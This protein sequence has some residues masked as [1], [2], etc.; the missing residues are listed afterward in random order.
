MSRALNDLPSYSSVAVVTLAV[1]DS[2]VDVM[3]FGLTALVRL[4]WTE[5]I[6]GELT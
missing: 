1:C 5:T 6:T 4:Q 3:S 2:T